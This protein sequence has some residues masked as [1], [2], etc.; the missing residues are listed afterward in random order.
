MSKE[1]PREFTQEDLKIGLISKDISPDSFLKKILELD[2]STPGREES[3]KNLALLED[4]DVRKIFE[5]GDY[6]SDYWN[7]LSFTYFHV[8]QIESMSGSVKAITFFESAL[9][10]A[11]KVDW[12]EYEIHWKYYVEATVAYFKKDIN[13]LEE[14]F[15][16]MEEGR[17]KEIVGN[18][19]KGL[20]LR[21]DIN[22]QEDYCQ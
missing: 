14:I 19:I 2:Q 4:E 8:G 13:K 9:L 15:L 10:M 1:R 11:E 18:F 20:K 17:N 22:Y 5:G 6:V 7:L 21:G 3:L 16:K 12:E